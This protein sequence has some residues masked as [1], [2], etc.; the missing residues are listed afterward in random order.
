MT[1]D[2]SVFFLSF[3]RP[4]RVSGCK[5]G[6]PEVDPS[7]LRIAFAKPCPHEKRGKDEKMKKGREEKRKRESGK[8]R[9]KKEREKKGKKGKRKERKRKGRFTCW[10][11][12]WERIWFPG[13]FPIRRTELSGRT[14]MK[15][16]APSLKLRTSLRIA[17][18]RKKL[19]MRLLEMNQRKEEY[20]V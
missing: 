7:T 13:L 19:W 2:I 14:T 12:F 10:N 18:S 3:F 11:S 6:I 17:S 15:I 1:L 20:H 16:A 9:E 4:A 8:E 5:N